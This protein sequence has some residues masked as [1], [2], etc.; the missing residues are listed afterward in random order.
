MV[1]GNPETETIIAVL[2]PIFAGTIQVIT[3]C[4]TDFTEVAR[5]NGE[6]PGA[7]ETMMLEVTVPKLFPNKVND[8]IPLVG[9]LK[10]L[11]LERN[12]LL[13][14]NFWPEEPDSPSTRTVTLS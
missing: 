5:R 8:T 13:K 11:M 10:G 12:G 9:A 14:A 1:P 3:V 7:I 4:D 2:E 6:L